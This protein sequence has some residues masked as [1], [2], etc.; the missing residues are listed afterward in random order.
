MKECPPGAIPQPLDAS[1]TEFY[2]VIAPAAFDDAYKG[3]NKLP[4][5]DR[6]DT[7]EISP[8]NGVPFDLLDLSILT[9]YVRQITFSI[10]T[11]GPDQREQ[12]VNEVSKHFLNPLY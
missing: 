12:T 1:T 5:I 2:D 11:R 9:K 8:R 4:E 3:S 7:I 6:S 10:T